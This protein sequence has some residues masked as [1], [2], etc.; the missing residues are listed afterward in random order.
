MFFFFIF[1]HPTSTFR[2]KK[3]TKK[4]NHFFFPT[5]NFSHSLNS[6]ITPVLAYAGYWRSTNETDAPLFPCPGAGS[7]LGVSQAGGGGGGGS[8][9]SSTNSSSSLS[10]AALYDG[11]AAGDA[12]CVAGSRGPLCAVCAKDYY[13]FSGACRSCGD[14]ASGKLLV[15]AAAAALSVFLLAIFARSWGGADVG[16]GPMTKIKI[17]MNHVQVMSLLRDYDLLWPK[18]TFQ[19]LGWADALNLGVS[20]AA[21]ECFVKGFGFWHYYA[22]SE[23]A[24][25]AAIALCVCVYSSAGVFLKRA[26]KKV[27]AL[28]GAEAVAAAEAEAAV[29]A[30]AEKRAEEAEAAAAVESDDVIDASSSSTRPPPPVPVL[31]KTSADLLRASRSASRLQSLRSR[32]WKNAFWLVTLLYPRA[33]QAALQVFSLQK[34]DVGTFLAADLSVLVRPPATGVGACPASRVMGNGKCPLTTKFK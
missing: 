11:S 4:K 32:C 14:V 29:V 17:F 27:E 22:F 13:K 12:S 34:L 8:G 18:S 25:V 23:A 6:T 31:S 5:P 2:K 24:P 15:A 3:L 33:A 26:K 30:E 1:F 21:P 7:C 9:A 16:P 28:G 19:A 20:V 10:S